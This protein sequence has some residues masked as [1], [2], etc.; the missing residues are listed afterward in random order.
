MID[1]SKIR[2]MDVKDV[3]LVTIVHAAHRLMTGR[4]LFAMLREAARITVRNIISRYVKPGTISE[5]LKNL[6][7]ILTQEEFL[8]SASSI[9]SKFYGDIIEIEISNCTFFKICSLVDDL[10]KK[11]PDIVKLVHVRPCAIAILYITAIEQFNGKTYD[12]ESVEYGT[13]CRVRLREIKL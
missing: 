2:I 9:S 3:A 4:G 10:I 6:D 13:T 12:T 8:K 5:T 7:T 11:R 1:E